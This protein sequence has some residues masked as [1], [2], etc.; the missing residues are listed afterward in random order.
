[1]DKVV[2]CSNLLGFSR[3]KYSLSVI[4]CLHFYISVVGEEDRDAIGKHAKPQV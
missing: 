3:G 2:N 4:K 1:M